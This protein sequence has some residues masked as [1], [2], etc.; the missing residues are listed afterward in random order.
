MENF[1]FCAV[2]N[3]KKL[4]FLMFK[5]AQRKLQKNPN[6]QKIKRKPNTIKNQLLLVFKIKQNKDT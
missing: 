5:P 1:I 3:N 4:N 6:K 2:N